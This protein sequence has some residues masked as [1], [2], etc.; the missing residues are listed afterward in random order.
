MEL[1]IKSAGPEVVGEIISLKPSQ[2]DASN[3]MRPIDPV[4]ATALG[5]FMAVDGQMTPVQVC[6]LPGRSDYTLVSGGHRHAG[7]EIAGIEL[8]AE[9]VSADAA[10]RKLREIVENLQRRDL[11]PI[12]RATN[13]AELV[14]LHKVRNGIDPKKDGR[15][16]SANARWQ[17]EIKAEADDANVTMTVAYGWSEALADELGY[18][19]SVIERDLF[20]IRRLPSSIIA[21]LVAIHQGGDGWQ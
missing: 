13:I 19:R 9:V 5:G 15:A 7:A 8:R 10:E 18:S 17:K 11:N 14:A 3:R 1:A 21:K 4:W 6:R 16:A 2:I 12:D 20:L